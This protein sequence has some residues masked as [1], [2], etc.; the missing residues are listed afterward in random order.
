MDDIHLNLPVGAL[1]CLCLSGLSRVGSG[2]LGRIL[3]LG[4]NNRSRQDH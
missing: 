4:K 2:I 3:P 1:P